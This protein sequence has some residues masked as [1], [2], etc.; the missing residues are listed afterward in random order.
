MKKL[1]CPDGELQSKIFHET[2]E[3][4]LGTEYPTPE[5]PKRISKPKGVE[6]SPCEFVYGANEPV[7]SFVRLSEHF[8]N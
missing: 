3:L 4:K 8:Y 7:K 1:G 2:M 6:E 5:P